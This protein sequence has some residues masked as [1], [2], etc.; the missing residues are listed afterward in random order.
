VETVRTTS[1][2]GWT[3][4]AFSPDGKALAALDGPDNEIQ[5]YHVG[6]PAS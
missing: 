5:L 2:T 4:L 3:E 6:Y 1:L